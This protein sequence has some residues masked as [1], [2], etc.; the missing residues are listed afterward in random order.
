[1]EIGGFDPEMKARIDWDCA[2]RLAPLGPIAFVDEPLALQRFSA[3][4]ITQD[5]PRKL[6]ARLRLVDKHAALFARHPAEL[7]LQHYGIASEQ[8]AL[9]DLVGA[10]RS[11]ARARAL[12]PR[13]PRYWAMSAW[14]AARSLAP[15]RG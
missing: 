14:V 6:A 10:R 7:A 4:S 9:G 3:N 2:L 5:A 11:L 8:R 13:T 1:M 12:A 15:G